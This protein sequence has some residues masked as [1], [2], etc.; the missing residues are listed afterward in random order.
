MSELSKP[1]TRRRRADAERSIVATLDAAINLLGRRP[2]ATMEEIAAEA[3]VARQTVYAHFASRDALLNAIVDRI[4]AEVVAAIDAVELETGPAA[5]TLSRWADASWTLLHRYPILLSPVMASANPQEEHER[6]LPITQR[7]D[8]LIRRG[9]RSGE[10]HRDTPA[11]W[12]V[13]AILSLGHTAGQQVQ[14][15]LMSIGDAGTAFRESA[16]RLC[17]RDIDPSGP[18]DTGKAAAEGFDD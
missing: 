6:H 5:D 12:L 1:R 7:L 2:E 14:A 15:D 18:A 9:Q 13:A 8:S 10:F 3:G 11:D 16:R 17:A 4:T